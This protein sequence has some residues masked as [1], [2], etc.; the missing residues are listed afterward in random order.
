MVAIILVESNPVPGELIWMTV[1][2]C[3][4]AAY[5][6]RFIWRDATPMVVHQQ[7]QAGKIKRSN[8][9]SRLMDLLDEDEMDDLE[10]WM[11][12]RRDRRHLE[13]ER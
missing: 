7:E 8:H 4:A 5:S 10:A 6:T 11:D 3:A 9:I 2:L 13:T 12:A 1:V